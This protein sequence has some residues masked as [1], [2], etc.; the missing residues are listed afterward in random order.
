MPIIKKFYEHDG[1]RELTSRWRVYT[2]FYEA[3]ERV[4][5]MEEKEE[6]PKVSYVVVE[7]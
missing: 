3:V 6:N 2:S 7:G 5:K 4:R 1:Y